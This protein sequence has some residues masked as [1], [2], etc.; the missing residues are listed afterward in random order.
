MVEQLLDF[1]RIR[2][3]GSLRCVRRPGNLGILPAKAIDEIETEYPRRVIELTS[4]GDLDGIWDVDRLGQMVRHLA[5]NAIAHGDAD[6]PVTVRI[7]D[8]GDAVE[9]TVHH[10]GRPIQAD[11]MEG[12]FHPF[13]RAS[14]A[15]TQSGL[16][17]G[18]FVVHEIVRAHGGTMHVESSTEDGTLFSVRLR[19]HGGSTH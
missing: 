5:S 15:I 14:Q 6:S 11:E 12:I 4:E 17:L 13:R 10:F 18:L 7:A 1:T 19:R 2:V 9:L 3:S 16:D 8:R